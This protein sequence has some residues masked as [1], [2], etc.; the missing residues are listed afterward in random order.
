MSGAEIT[1]PP[2]LQGDELGTELVARA[3]ARALVRLP[4]KEET[5]AVILGGAFL[6]AAGSAALFLPAVRPFSVTE[7]FVSVAVY[8]AVARIRFEVSNGFVLPT[9]LV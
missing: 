2:S 5:L 9:Q 6:L 1:A 4:R 8:A 7:A 3:R